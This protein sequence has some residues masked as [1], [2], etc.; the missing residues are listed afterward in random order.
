[1]AINNKNNDRFHYNKAEKTNKNFMYKDLRR[2][3]CYN[4]N[5]TGSNFSF[6][7]FRGAHFKACDFFDCKFEWTEFIG[8]NLKN[9]KFRKTKFENVVFEGVNL[10]GADFTGAKFKN[11]IFVDTDISKA[12]NMKLSYGL[13]KT[14]DEM[15]ELEIS[16]D[17]KEAINTA[18]GNEFVKKSRVLDNKE[19]SINTISVMRLLESFNEKTLILGLKSIVDRVDREFCTLSYI[20]KAIEKCQKEG[21]L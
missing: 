2:A 9:S 1:M 14:F 12:T 10:D 8:S 18:M 7:S 21:M 15:P 4:C 19:G 3:N 5:F 6:A 20:I 13:Y 11:V 17:L 16:E